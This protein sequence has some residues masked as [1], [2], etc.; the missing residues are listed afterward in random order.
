[1]RKYELYGQCE[2]G[3]RG[4]EAD[5]SHLQ[6]TP[7]LHGEH[8]QLIHHEDFDRRKKVSVPSTNKSK[9]PAFRQT[10]K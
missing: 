6:M 9:H 5:Q 8:V 10:T 3:S 7:V 4:D 2:I 1:M